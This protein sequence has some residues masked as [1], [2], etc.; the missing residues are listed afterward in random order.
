[1]S[2]TRSLSCGASAMTGRKE[3]ALWELQGT[4]LGKPG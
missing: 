3:D 1:M 4:Q 2:T